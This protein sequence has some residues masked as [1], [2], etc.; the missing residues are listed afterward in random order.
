MREITVRPHLYKQFGSKNGVHFRLITN[1]C[2]ADEFSI[3]D[4][5]MYQS[6]AVVPLSKSDEMNRLLEGLPR[7][8]HVL[9][10]LPE[11]LFQS[12]SQEVLGNQCKLLVIPCNST[13]IASA[14][15]SHYLQ[16]MESTDPIAQKEWSDRFFALGEKSQFLLMVDNTFGTEAKF[17]HLAEDY[18][19]FEQLGPLEYGGQQF[20]PS[21]EV[22]VLPLFHGNYDS[23]RR[24]RV[25]GRIS[26]Y[27]LPIVN[28]GKP[29]FL[30]S[31]QN[32]IFQRL[33]VLNSHPVI[34]TVTNGAIDSL[35]ATSEEARHASEMLEMLFSVD[36]RY[37]IIW[38]IGF[39]AN[40]KM[41]VIKANRSPNE[42]YGHR[43]G[44][45]HWGLGLTPWTQYHIDIICPNTLIQSDGGEVLA[46]GHT[47]YHDLRRGSDKKMHRQAAIGCPC[48]A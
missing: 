19:W 12:P 8:L 29:S 18:E 32:K 28:S 3:D 26:L 9:V 42:S 2:I 37:R 27:G 11:T 7:P 48:I 20:A 31:D 5:G 47:N 24:L 16:V 22:S 41:E 43:N 13:E 35:E 25:N 40:T 45:I 30:R 46:G 17:E 15:I 1:S 6:V 34:A 4:N 38:E 21:G 36:S 33:S 14:D 44:A 10:I 39:G 23:E